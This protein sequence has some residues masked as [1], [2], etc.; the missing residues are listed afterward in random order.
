MCFHSTISR[1]ISTDGRRPVTS[2]WCPASFLGGVGGRA[3][4]DVEPA[5]GGEHDRC[6]ALACRPLLLRPEP[7]QGLVQISLDTQTR[8]AR[9]EAFIV[10]PP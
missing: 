8:I 6:Q 7:E 10:A 9:P 3:V 4:R 2:N 1:S 5:T